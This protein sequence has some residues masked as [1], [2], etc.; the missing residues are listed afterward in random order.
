MA[1]IATLLFV[2]VALLP[3]IGNNVDVN[4]YFPIERR[5]VYIG[6]SEFLYAVVNFDANAS[7]NPL[8]YP[9]SWLAGRGSI[10][11]SFSMVYVP[12]WTGGSG[13]TPPTPQWGKPQQIKSEATMKIVI[14]ELLNNLPILPA[15]FFVVELV[16]RRR[17][18]WWFLGGILGFDFGA[19]TGAIVGFSLAVFSTILVSR[20]F[21][22]LLRTRDLDV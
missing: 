10:V 22:R 6:T 13:N 2:V 14:E 12:Y 17:F 8:L 4:V 5:R 7:F 11:G 9:V 15:V 19:L 1:L 21:W 20:N 16:E 3:Y 18:Y